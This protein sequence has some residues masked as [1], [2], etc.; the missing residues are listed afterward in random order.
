MINLSSNLAGK[1]KTWT[2][3]PWTPS[4]DSVHGPGPSK[5]G[6]GPSKCGPGPSKCGPGPWTGFMDLVHGPLFLPKQK[7]TKTTKQIKG[8]LKK[9]DVSRFPLFSNEAVQERNSFT[10]DE[11]LKDAL[12][13]K[14]NE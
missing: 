9:E 14:N 10:V 2:P 13:H 7:Q 3:G 5:C 1:Y 11:Q 8:H 6:P 12:L 4:V